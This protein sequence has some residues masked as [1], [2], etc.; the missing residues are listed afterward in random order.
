MFPIEPNPQPEQLFDNLS[1]ADFIRDTSATDEIPLKAPID[2]QTFAQLAGVFVTAWIEQ[3]RE[4]RFRNHAL[5]FNTTIRR[6]FEMEGDE[7]GAMFASRLTR[8]ARAMQASVA[9]V[10][11]IGFSA[12]LP[13]HQRTPDL[14]T[15]LAAGLAKGGL[16]WVALRKPAEED[17]IRIAGFVPFDGTRQSGPAEIGQPDDD[18]TYNYLLEASGA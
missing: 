8:E 16:C 4:S 5:L 11:T 6:A 2:E 9:L 15:A 17:T 12:T 14:D 13:P 1:V 3:Y 7:T 10:A 18:N